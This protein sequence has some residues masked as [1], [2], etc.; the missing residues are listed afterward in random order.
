MSLQF[1]RCM[2]CTSWIHKR[3][4]VSWSVMEVGTLRRTPWMTLAK[5]LRLK[6]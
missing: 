5:S 2:Y 4:S 1:N 6:R 3:L